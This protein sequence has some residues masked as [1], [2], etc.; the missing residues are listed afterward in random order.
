[1]EVHEP[2]GVVRVECCCDLGFEAKTLSE[3]GRVRGVGHGVE[4]SESRQE[5]RR[6]GGRTAKGGH[7]ADTSDKGRTAKGGQGADTSDKARIARL[8]ET[9][10]LAGGRAGGVFFHKRGR[11]IGF[12]A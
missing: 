8:Q 7:G 10:G 9:N 4:S 3:V 12:E 6:T 1:Q 5:Y 2:T 11:S